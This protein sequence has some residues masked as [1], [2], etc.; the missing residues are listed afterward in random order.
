MPCEDSVRVSVVTLQQ[1]I[2]VQNDHYKLGR[3]IYRIKNFRN[4]NNEGAE[5]NLAPITILT[6]ANGAGKS[7][8]VKSLM[9]LKT[10]VSK[11]KISPYS[12]IF[13]KQRPV[14]ETKNPLSF[15]EGELKLGRFDSAVNAGSKDKVMTFEYEIDS[16][17]LGCPVIV[18]L[19][20]ISDK[21][22]AMNNGWLKSVTIT[23]RDEE[24]VYKAIVE[25]KKIELPFIKLSWFKQ[26]FIK[27]G[28]ISYIAD[29]V[30]AING[31]E[32]IGVNHSL[33]ITKETIHLHKEL[34]SE[35]KKLIKEK[36]QKSEA[37]LFMQWLKSSDKELVSTKYVAQFL[38]TASFEVINCETKFLRNLCKLTKEEAIEQIS[39]ISLADT[40]DSRKVERVKKYILSSLQSSEE[41]YFKDWYSAQ[42]NKFLDTGYELNIQPLYFLEYESENINLFDDDNTS[43]EKPTV[44][45]EESLKKEVT[46]SDIVT[47]LYL[48][49]NEVRKL[50]MENPIDMPYF[51]YKGY[52]ST[53]YS[54]V[55][56][57][58]LP[59]LLIPDFVREMHYLGSAQVS[60]QRLYSNQSGNNSFSDLLLHYFDAKRNYAGRYECDSFLNKWIKKFG[61]G[62]SLTLK[63]TE[64]GTGLLALLHE[65]PGDEGRLLADEGYGITQLLSILLN[66]ETAILTAKTHE[67]WESDG[68]MLKSIRKSEG[69]I[70]YLAQT[71]AIEEPENHLH[72]RLQS[73]LADMFLDAYNKYNIHFIVE[74]H[75]EY[76]IRKSQVLVASM[77]F[78][79]NEEAEMK[80]P[81]RTYYLQ[82]DEQ[83]YS[84]GYR[85]DGKFVNEFGEGFYDEAASL[86]F[87]ML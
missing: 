42:E 4:F 54:Y 57:A 61:L 50:I 48:A 23:N 56:D 11:N 10:Y 27:A 49:D 9:A 32:C 43:P 66:I 78:S 59:E 84:L 83:P 65:K 34:L 38:A 2:T 67:S 30:E 47:F 46:F 5:F 76:L 86:M 1:I 51:Q 63:N 37:A 73:L 39:K 53:L 72:P 68:Y 80:S 62:D 79:S 13:K 44:T 3:M 41:G 70:K 26:R 40:F 74:T 16:L 60:V 29:T 19:D 17:S 12:N 31:D 33:G 20:F 81:F 15:Q 71:I 7:S 35:L 24:V 85:K 14:P 21:D 82:R 45:S 8:L 6:G 22:D 69:R 36:I 58:V 18:S 77:N 52:L 28:L 87:Q 75:S 25:N 64:A 55:S